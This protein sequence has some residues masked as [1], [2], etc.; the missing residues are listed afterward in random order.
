MHIKKKSDPSPY[1][2]AYNKSRAQLNT[3]KD[4]KFPKHHK[5]LLFPKDESPEKQNAIVNLL[6]WSRTTP[7]AFLKD[8]VTMLHLPFPESL[9]KD[10]WT[11]S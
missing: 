1:S 4:T 6:I 9:S 10:S 2:T 3:M 8:L 7:M 5:L 11:D